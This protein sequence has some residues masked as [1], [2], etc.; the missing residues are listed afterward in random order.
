MIIILT[1]PDHA[2]KTTQ[3]SIISKQM[4]L[5]TFKTSVCKSKQLFDES[6]QNVIK[7]RRELDSVDMPVMFLDRFHYPDELIY[8]PIVE[9]RLSYLEPAGNLYLQR[10]LQEQKTIFVVL[11]ADINVLIN[12]H[13]ERG[14]YYISEEHL[15]QIYEQYEKFC[16]DCQMPVIR[17][18]TSKDDPFDTTFKMASAIMEVMARGANDVENS[19]YRTHSL[20]RIH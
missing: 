8:T 9:N 2:G 17:I 20:L 13:R 16:A 11:T 4:Q 14:D 3:A 19:Y 6:V 18:D 10:W 7:T 15:A 1:G 5:P 12:R